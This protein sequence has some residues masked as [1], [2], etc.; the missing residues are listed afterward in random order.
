MPA[1]LEIEDLEVEG[2][3]PG[4]RYQPIVKGISLSVDRGEVVALIGESGSGKT[5]VSLA[6]LG[7]ARPGCRISGG[8]VRLDGQDVLA[9]SHYERR[10]LRGKRVA[11]VA[12]SAAAA[13]N[14]ARKIGDQVTESSRIPP[15]NERGRGPLPRAPDVSPPRAARSGQHQPALSAPGQR[16]ATP[17]ADGGDGDELRSGAAGARRAD[18]RAGRD[19][20][21]RGADRL[22]GDHQRARYRGDLRHPRSVGGGADRGSDHRHVRRPGDGTGLH[23]RH[24]LQPAARLH[25]D[26]DG[27]VAPAPEGGP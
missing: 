9:L 21:D 16:R 2:R 17:A 1:L 11:Y 14:P 24:H 26:P 8:Q 5:T 15:G 3:P 22:E 25:Q 12:Q 6:S 4:G 7:Y 27:G 19:H 18:H 13:F 10:R 20:P 23:R